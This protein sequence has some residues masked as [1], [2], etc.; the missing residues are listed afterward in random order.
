M[1][2]MRNVPW[3]LAL[4]AAP[5][6]AQMPAK[7]LD[8][9]AIARDADRLACYDAAVADSSSEARAA[10]ERRARES[11]RIAAEEAAVAAAAAKQKAEADAIAEAAAR[12]EAFGAEAVASRPERFQAPPGQIQQIDAV[13]TEV[14]TNRSG[15][16]VFLLDNGQIWR[17]ADTDSLPNVRTG[18]KVTIK[19]ALLGGYDMTFERSHRTV[20]VKRSR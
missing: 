13:V 17:Q 16:G 9:A 6:A 3:L 7:L 2:L 18:E 1:R 5:A 11:A 14:L 12:K 20:L 15:L 10:S 8:C 19:R 4:V